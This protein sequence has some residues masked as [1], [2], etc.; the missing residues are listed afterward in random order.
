MVLTNL[1]I[2]LAVRIF[3]GPRTTMLTL[4]V[5]IPPRRFISGQLTQQGKAAIAI[6]DKTAEPRAK[7]VLF[8]PVTVQ[9][10]ALPGMMRSS[11]RRC[12]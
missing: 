5:T 7:L 10:L 3:S 2:V 4:Q 11:R 8:L 6:F 9:Y 12:F 1:L